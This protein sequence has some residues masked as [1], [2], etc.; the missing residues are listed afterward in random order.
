MVDR[1]L[2]AGILGLNE[3]GRILLE[4][5][6]ASNYYSIAAI[7]DKDAKLVEK[8]AKEYGCNA[9][10]NFRQLIIQN[11]LDCLLIG[12]GLHGCI[13]YIQQAIKK[14]FNILKWPPVG[15][16]FE[17]AV[18]LVKLAEDNGVQL[19]IANINRLSE[20]FSAFEKYI[21]TGEIEH[22]YLLEVVCNVGGEVFPAWHNDREL[23]GGGVLLRN[24][25]ELIDKALMVFSLPQ[26]VYCAATNTAGDRQQRHYLTEDTATVIL[27]FRE[28]F[29]GR[30]TASKVFGPKESFI[31]IFGK[32]KNLKLCDD[33]ISISDNNGKLIEERRY[34]FQAK[35]S[36]KQLLDKYALTLLKPDKN[37]PYSSARENLRNIAVIESA[38]LS[39]KTG[40]PESV[41][42]VLDMGHIEAIN[43]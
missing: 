6:N 35:V 18:E 11:E 28:D 40:M 15:R 5:V 13:E 36:A 21:E 19:G 43:M 2:R 24:C 31:R 37:K 17:E 1:K 7:A 42:R 29:I 38:Y 9:Y 16:C 20:S 30:I 34:P 23:S 4:A 27:K 22:I 3:Q 26:E 12:T 10:D 8:T 41:A 39:S 14:K 32:E 33:Y 25:Y